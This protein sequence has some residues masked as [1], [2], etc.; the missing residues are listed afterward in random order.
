MTAAG[1]PQRNAGPTNSGGRESSAR[2]EEFV[3][4][5]AET[6][7]KLLAYL[8]ALLQDRMAVED[9]LQETNLVL[10]REL[11]TFSPGTNF[12]AWACRVAYNQARAW[13]KT[14]KRER[15]RFT[16]CFL[17]A[18]AR[19]LDGYAEEIGQ[20]LDA[21]SECVQQLPDHHRELIRFRYADGVAVEAIAA[22]VNRS[23]EAVYRMLSRI[24]M[25]LMKCVRHKMTSYNLR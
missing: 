22:E 8:T 18:V 3:Q 25:A 11:D 16:D 21:L 24:R 2:V 12:S 6:Q 20:R 4:L 1:S 7:Q 15:L 14:Q 9:V 13:R 19:E 5:L 10:W 23:S 17:E